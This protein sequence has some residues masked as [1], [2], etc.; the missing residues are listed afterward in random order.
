MA[1]NKY[2][3]ASKIRAYKEGFEQA[4]RLY[5]RPHA[6]WCYMPSE[7]IEPHYYCSNCGEQ[8]WGDSERDNFLFCPWCGS[9]MRKETDNVN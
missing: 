9:D 1:E 4:K 5:Q 6:E 8:A 7:T 2:S 3:H